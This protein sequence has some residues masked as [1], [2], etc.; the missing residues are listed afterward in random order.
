MIKIQRKMQLKHEVTEKIIIILASII[1]VYLLISLFFT[2]HFFLHTEINGVNVSLKSHKDTDQMIRDY[3]NSYQLQLIERNGT[4]EVIEA[5][6]IGMRL[7]Q[8]NSI[9]KIHRIQKSFRWVN[10]FFRDQD[11]RLKDVF[12]YDEASLRK[13]IDGL[14]CLNTSTVE[15]RNV[16]FQ[17]KNGSYELIQEVYGNKINQE[18]LIDAIKKHIQMGLTQLDLDQNKCYVNPKYTVNSKKTHETYALLNKYVAT[19]ITYEF[20]DKV[21]LVDGN[22]IN[23]WLSV[24]DNFDIHIDKAAVREYMKDLSKKYDTVGI[25]RQFK[26]ST[27][28]TVEVKGGLYG[29]KMDQETETKAVIE[30]ITLGQIIK[31]EPTYLQTAISRGEDEIGNTYVEINIT[32]QHLWFYKEG[33]LIAQGAVVTGN[34]NRGNATVLGIYMLNYKQ[35]DAMLSGPGYEVKVTYWMPFFGN[36]GLHDASWRYNFGGQIYKVNGTH[37]CVNASYYLAKKIFENIDSG[38]PII[39]YEE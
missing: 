32:R 4:M 7:N 2:K 29:W 16:G 30:H 15:P 34:P 25:A 13:K 11:Y 5:H 1:F 27:G 37:G 22:I 36:I 6:E 9:N 18:N 12:A 35:R 23:E 3:I 10:S 31:K 14:N 8:N 21:E 20:G 33:K 28:K 39:S 26:T 24:D 19:K 38:V 17:Y